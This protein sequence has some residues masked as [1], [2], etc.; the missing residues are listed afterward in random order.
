MATVTGNPSSSTWMEL[1]WFWPTSDSQV[2]GMSASSSLITV[3]L[4]SGSRVQYNGTFDLNTAT[5]TITSIDIYFGNTLSFSVTGLT[6]SLTTWLSNSFDQDLPTVLAGND[7]LTG[8]AGYPNHLLGYAGDDTLN[9]GAN[10]DILDGGI[11]ADTMNGGDGNDQYIVNHGG[12]VI[13]DTAGTDS[14]FSWTP[15]TLGAGLENLVLLQGTISGY[16]NSLANTIVGSDAANT[17]RGDGGGDTLYGGGGDDWL[18][19]EAGNQAISGVAGNDIIYG[20]GGNDT[21]LAGDGDDTLY[22][23]SGTDALVGE[24]GNDT[25]YGGADWDLMDGRDG[26]DFMYGEGGA[27]IIFGDVGADQIDGGEG[28][29]LIMGERGFDSMTGD[30]DTIVGGVGNDMLDGSAGNDLILGG[31]GNDIIDGDHGND[32]IIGGAGAE[33][34]A[35]TD[36]NGVNGRDTFVYESTADAGDWIYGFRNVVGDSDQIDLI[37]LFNNSGY[38]GTNPRGDGYLAIGVSGGNTQIYVDANGPAGG[39]NWVLLLSLYQTTLDPSNLDSYF[40]Y[41]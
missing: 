12:D 25:I 22:G 14:V 30:D 41:Q 19:G 3:N 34:I 36:Y 10:D 20:E 26:I 11:G 35:G 24:D 17:L 37:T 13:T 5:G 16:G 18:E 2:S 21:V 28:D 1:S 7:T 32:R 23:G 9:G 39:G 4:T 33:I 38:T 27:D 8:S 40:I 15:Y 29:D 31:V 6:Y